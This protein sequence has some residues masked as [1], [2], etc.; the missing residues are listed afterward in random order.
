MPIH[1]IFRQTLPPR[2]GDVRYIMAAGIIS[3][4]H[5]L[6]WT[7]ESSVEPESQ[8]GVVTGIGISVPLL[9]ESCDGYESVVYYGALS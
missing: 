9:T 2:S 7:S 5:N 6:P 8:T 1:R 3:T 4:E